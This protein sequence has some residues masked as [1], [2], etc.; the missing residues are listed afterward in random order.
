LALLPALA[1]MMMVMAVA[2]TM[3]DNGRDRQTTTI[4]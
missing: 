3:K 1:T 2:V 4:N